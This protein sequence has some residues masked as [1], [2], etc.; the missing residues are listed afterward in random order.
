MMNTQIIDRVF[1]A[2]LVVADLT[3]RT[4]DVLCDLAIGYAVKKPTVHLIADDE[5]IPLDI[6]QIKIIQFKLAVRDNLDRAREQL[7][8]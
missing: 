8:G 2:D 7:T 3:G 4:P 5:E 1:E 6:N